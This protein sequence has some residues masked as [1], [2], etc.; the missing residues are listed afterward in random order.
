MFEASLLNWFD[1]KVVLKYYIMGNFSKK[2]K[3]SCSICM[4]STKMTQQFSDYIFREHNIPKKVCTS[5]DEF[6]LPLRV[7]IE[8][9]KAILSSL[10]KSVSA[11]FE[12]KNQFQEVNNQVQRNKINSINIFLTYLFQTSYNLQSTWSGNCQEIQ[13]KS[14]LSCIVTDKSKN[15]SE[16]D[17][18]IMFVLKYEEKKVLPTTVDAY[19][20]KT[21]C[22]IVFFLLILIS[23]YLCT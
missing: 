21:K 20:C 12:R 14:P 7:S 6:K 9:G 1:G 13:I 22:I 17:V 2:C 19:L 15:K 3:N 23:L 8:E 11:F 5:L 10:F 18:N 4:L 16:K